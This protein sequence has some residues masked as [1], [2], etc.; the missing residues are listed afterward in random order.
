MV[1]MGSLSEVSALFTDVPPPPPLR[2]RLI[3]GGVVVHVTEPI[4]P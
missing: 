1:R 3:A 2:E 4:G